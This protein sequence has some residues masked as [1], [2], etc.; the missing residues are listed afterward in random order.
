MNVRGDVHRFMLQS[1]SAS[2]DPFKT[3]LSLR[4]GIEDLPPTAATFQPAEFVD[5]GGPAIDRGMLTMMRAWEVPPAYTSGSRKN[6]YVN[7]YYEGREVYSDVY[8][9]CECGALMVREELVGGTPVAQGEHQHTEDCRK[10][11]RYRAKARLLEKRREVMLDGYWHGLSGAQMAPRMGFSSPDAVG[12]IAAHLGV[13]G[14]ERRAAGKRVRAR[15]MARLLERHSP[16]LVGEVYG[17]SGQAV[18]A[19]VDRH[20]DASP[21][22]LY[23]QRRTDQA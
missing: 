6:R 21:A 23:E 17:L 4:R 3:A 1:D 9:E 18:R 2:I 10:A 15:T 20:T 22:D 5:G 8:A 12:R 13:E 11:W 14:D 16:R 7:P 19:A